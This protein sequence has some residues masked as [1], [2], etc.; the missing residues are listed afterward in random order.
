MGYQARVSNCL[1]AYF[2]ETEISEAF[3]VL[4]SLPKQSQHTERLLE[5]GSG[6]GLVSGCFLLAGPP[7]QSSLA[8]I[9]SSTKM[10]S[11]QHYLHSSGKAQPYGDEG[12]G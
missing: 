2:H 10:L 11:Q 5:G 4:L 8:V 7:G 3:T 6:R 12:P 1:T 9:W